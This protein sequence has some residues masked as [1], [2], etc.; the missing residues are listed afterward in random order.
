MTSRLSVIIVNYNA[1]QE[2]ANC[3]HSV[4]EGGDDVE[5]I[6]VDNDSQDGSVQYLREQY[7]GKPR[8]ILIENEK[9]LGFAVACNQGSRAATGE[10]LLYLNPDCVVEEDTLSTL[11]QVLEDSSEAGMVGGLILNHDGTEQR[12]CRRTIPTP[13]KSLVN[14]LGLQALARVN[15]NLFADFR[16]DSTPLPSGPTP[17]EAIS[18]ACMLVSRRAFHDVGPMDEEYFL[19]CEDLDWCMRFGQKGWKILFVPQARLV[20]SKGSCSASR[21]IFVEWSKHKGMVRFYRKFFAEEDSLLTFCFVW[22]GIWLRFGLAVVKIALQKII[23][24]GHPSD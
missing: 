7:D 13:W 17:V 24:K 21:P 20:H 1:G 15:K 18:G 16:L 5:I 22:L 2:L 4:V 8:L 9:N 10:F 6:V 11:C 23:P 19:H 14:S 12:G 3:V